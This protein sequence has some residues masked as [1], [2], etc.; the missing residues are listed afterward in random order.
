MRPHISRRLGKLVA[1]VR[2]WG[3]ETGNEIESLVDELDDEIEELKDE[4]NELEGVIDSN[5]DEV[6][7]VAERLL[8]S[9][10]WSPCKAPQVG[11]MAELHAVV[12]PI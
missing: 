11:E 2:T 7:D 9:A 3:E 4:V 5:R 8:R 12:W 10:G 6:I 1:S